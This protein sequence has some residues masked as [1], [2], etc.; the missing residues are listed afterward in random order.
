MSQFRFITLFLCRVDAEDA[1]YLL[2]GKGAAVKRMLL[3]YVEKRRSKTDNLKNLKQYYCRQIW[4]QVYHRSLSEDDLIIT[5]FE[6]LFWELFECS[7]LFLTSCFEIRLRNILS[8]SNENGANVNPAPS[9][10]I[11]HIQDGQNAPDG[12]ESNGSSSIDPIKFTIATLLAELLESDSN[13]EDKDIIE[14][15]IFACTFGGKYAFEH[16]LETFSAQFGSATDQRIGLLLIY[17]IKKCKDSLK[18][19][20]KL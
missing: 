15:V 17:L 6:Q 4:A 16:D 12:N 3:S 1:Q 5:L 10:D 20:L 13:H 14:K 7:T 2:Q 8:T 19:E 9:T 18:N 11:I